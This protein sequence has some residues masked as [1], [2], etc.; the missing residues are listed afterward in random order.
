MPVVTTKDETYDI[1]G[2]AEKVVPFLIP[3]VEN[4]MVLH[5]FLGKSQQRKDCKKSTD[6]F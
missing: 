2:T 5:V 1:M 6:D 3:Q 4:K